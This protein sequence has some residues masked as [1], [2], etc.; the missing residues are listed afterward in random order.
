[1]AMKKNAVELLDK[2]LSLRAKKNQY[3]IVVMSSA[4]DPYV[5]LEKEYELTRHLLEVIYKYRFPLHVITKSD[6]VLRDLD[7]LKKIEETAILP[8]G[9]QDKLRHRVFVTF[10]FSTIDEKIASI[11]E[12]G[13]PSPALRLETL[14]SVREAGF[15]SGVSMMPLLPYISDTTEQLEKIFQAIQQAKANYVFPS[16]LTL[17]GDGRADSKTLVLRAVEK[18]YSEL[19]EKY[20]RLFATNLGLPRYY[21]EAFARKAKELSLKY[22]LKNTLMELEN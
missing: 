7:I 2:Q 1:M 15:A 20:K 16:T 19:L 8:T 6:L 3:G 18:H 9:L 13:A 11:F 21:T 5:H 22:G 12:P 14:R 4:T 10:S 17:Y